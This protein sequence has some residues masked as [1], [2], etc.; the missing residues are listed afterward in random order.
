MRLKTLG[1]G[2]FMTLTGLAQAQKTEV[3]WWDFL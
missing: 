1:F 2:I 3:V